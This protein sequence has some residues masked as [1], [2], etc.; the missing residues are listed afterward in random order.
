[1]IESNKENI[2]KNSPKYFESNSLAL[3]KENVQYAIQKAQNLDIKYRKL[4]DKYREVKD[5]Y[6]TQEKILLNLKQR[7]RDQSQY[8]ELSFDRA[9]T[10]QQEQES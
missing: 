10:L 6:K 1:M 5:K 2:Q 7:R 8:G 9:E 3:N 4:K